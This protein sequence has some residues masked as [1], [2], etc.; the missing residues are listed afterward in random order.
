MKDIHIFE[1]AKEFIDFIKS[2]PE[3]E[4]GNISDGSMTAVFDTVTHANVAIGK[5][6]NTLVKVENGNVSS[7]S[8]PELRGMANGQAERLIEELDNV[9]KRINGDCNKNIPCNVCLA[10]RDRNKI[11]REGI[12]IGT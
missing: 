6:D 9:R 8:Y 12:D 11:L 5:Q 1:N 2:F 4:R 3:E 7:I 10:F